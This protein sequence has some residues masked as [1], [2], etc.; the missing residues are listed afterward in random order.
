M[1]SKYTAVYTAK[2]KEVIE[3]VDKFIAGKAVSIAFPEL[4]KASE[5]K[6][7]AGIL[8]FNAEK[9]LWGNANHLKPLAQMVQIIAKKKDIAIGRINLTS[10]VKGTVAFKRPEAKA[11]AKELEAAIEAAIAGK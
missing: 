4:S 8:A 2:A 10:D 6:S 11:G 5:K 9:I 3:V 7:L 1:G